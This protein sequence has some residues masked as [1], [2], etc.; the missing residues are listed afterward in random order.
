MA[1]SKNLAILIGNVGKDPEI[2][3]TRDGKKIANFS[4]AT[5]ESWTDKG[6]G[7]RRD[8][9]EWH[10]VVVFNERVADVVEK[11]LRKGHKVAVEGQIKSRKW[12]D[13]NG[14]DRYTTEI[15]I[16]PF[17]GEVTLLTPQDKDD[18]R[19]NRR[20]E[21]PA[22]GREEDDNSGPSWGSPKSGGSV[23]DDQI[24]F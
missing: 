10:T 8:Q 13:K 21:R 2:R 22:A 24:P 9:T 7:E 5:S 16:G 15:V 3:M 14:Q 19:D 20:S 4:V 6:S 11:Y 1:G 23:E 12:Q 18:N 17:K